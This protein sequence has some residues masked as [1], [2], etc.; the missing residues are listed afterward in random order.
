MAFSQNSIYLTTAYF[1]P[2]QQTLEALLGASRRG[3]DVKIIL[4]GKSDSKLAYYG[5]RSYYTQLLKTGIR[6]YEFRKAMIHSKIAVIDKV[7]STVGSTNLDPWSLLRNY[8]V[9]AVILGRTFGGKMEDL[10]ADY[11]SRSDEIR[12]NEWKK[13]S[14]TERLREWLSRLVWYWL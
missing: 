5:G 6:V 9:N 13:R 12:L 3:V 8:E 11:L 4:P 2:D 1:A 14:T 10:F 7:W